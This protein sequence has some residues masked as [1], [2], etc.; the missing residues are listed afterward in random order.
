MSEKE[1]TQGSRLLALDYLRG[2]FVAVIIIDHL[3]KFPSIG[4][5]LTGEARLWVTAAEGFV[6][7]SGFLIGYVRGFKGLKLPFR[8]IAGKLLQRSLLLY[9]WVII[10]TIIFAAIDW[11]LEFIPNIPSPPTPDGDW[12]A[13]FVD[14]ATF[15]SA[16]LWTYFLLLYTIFLF[17][18]IGIVYLLRN[19]QARL[20]VV[21][22]LIV[23]LVGLT[24]DIKWMKWQVIFFLPTIAGYYFP[25]IITWWQ[26]HSENKRLWF[27]RSIYSSSLLLLVTSMTFIFHPQILPLS[28]VGP[29]NSLFNIETF[30]PLRILLSGLWFI[31]LALFFDQIFPFLQRWTFGVL[32][33][34]GTHSL[35]AYIAHGFI[36]CAFNAIL[37]LSGITEDYILDSAI[38]ILGILAVYGFIRI[39]LI[40][41]IIPR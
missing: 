3:N 22:T 19:N 21:L 40:A 10:T 17:F 30:G 37:F 32:E 8:V 9:V 34:I 23:Y 29:V 14:V 12:W 7:I 25:R 27:R 4:S 15:H 6:M 28:I 26:G 39:P 38:C 1:S 41:K 20:A 5:L 33:Y 2:F 13:L 18:S 11:Y 31:A 16:A 36:I 24:H 35:T